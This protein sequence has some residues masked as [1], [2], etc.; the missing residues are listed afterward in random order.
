MNIPVT[1]PVLGKEEID[2]VA[3]R[4]LGGWVV[5]GPKVK[6]FE[7]RFA[8][9]VGARFARATTSCTT[10]LH[11]ALITM[12]IGPGDEV[13][14]PALTY[15]ATANAVVYC[16]ATPVFV[17]IDLRTFNMDV[18]TIES[19]LT[20][21]TKAIIP[22]HE[23]GLP[24]DMDAIMNIAKKH[25]IAVL[26]DGACATGSRISKRHVGTFGRA[27]CFSFHP[28]KAITS[29][30][31]GMIV[32]DDEK[33]AAHVE[34]LRSHGASTSD[35]ARHSAPGSFELPDFDELGY[36]YR[37]TDIQAAIGVEQMKK[38][39]WIL[40]KRQERAARYTEKLAGIS[41]LTLPHTPAGSEH[42]FQS[43]VTVVEKSHAERNRVALALQALGIATRQGTHAVHALGYYR[44]RFGLTTES[45][46]VAWKA[47]Q[48][49]MTLP[50]YATMTDEEQD[51]VVAHVG[52]VM[53]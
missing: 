12:G 44:Q 36:N 10:A 17:D 47:D 16:G 35:L 40:A 21:R 42:A 50:L 8:E 19:K 51:Y 11:L 5:Q 53:T 18:S 43:Y 23:F 14:V 38:L 37:M 28:R 15:V 20:P 33:I 41:G 48:Q 49:S 32:T 34:V 1:K 39:P 6:E 13:L 29:G 27:G 22:V 31:G 9:Y 24:A 46:P 26:E 52:K 4:L 45:C 3:E 30:E 2:A 7:D 25:G